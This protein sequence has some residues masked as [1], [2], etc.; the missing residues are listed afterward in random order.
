MKRSLRRFMPCLLLF[1]ALGAAVLNGCAG[2]ER[3]KARQEEERE[4]EKAGAGEEGPIRGLDPTLRYLA[5]ESNYVTSQ[6]W[7]QLRESEVYKADPSLV[8]FVNNQLAL[9]PVYLKADEIARYTTDV[10][11]KSRVLIVEM[12]KKLTPADIK[13]RIKNA[14]DWAEK[15]VGGHALHDH[16]GWAFSIPEDRVLIWCGTDVLEKILERGKGPNLTPNMVRAMRLVDFSKSHVQAMACGDLGTMTLRGD[17]AKDKLAEGREEHFTS[18][19][20]LTNISLYKDEQAADAGKEAEEKLLT[21]WIHQR[22]NGQEM[23]EGYTIT[24]EGRTVTARWEV[25]LAKLKKIHGKK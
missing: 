1:L 7:D 21:Q 15:K 17:G 24:K 20:S 9:T 12:T 2:S 22:P 8:P 4:R 6:R 10:T 5:D 25:G 19:S 18:G 16:G 23:F 11:T 3:E 13:A 14:S